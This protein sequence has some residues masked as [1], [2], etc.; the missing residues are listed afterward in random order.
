M[1]PENLPTTP[2]AYDHSE[3]TFWLCVL[4]ADFNELIYATYLGSSPDENGIYGEHTHAGTHKFDTRGIIYHS[5][6]GM[7]QNFPTTPN[8]AFPSTQTRYLDNIA[9]KFDAGF[10][11]PA[12]EFILE[13]G[14]DSITC[15][16]APYSAEFI[17]QSSA[18]DY[19]IWNFGDGSPSV[20]VDISQNISHVFSD[21][22]VFVVSLIAHKDSVCITDDTAFMTIRVLETF[23]PE[24]L[25]QDTFICHSQ[26]LIDI[27]VLI[28][29][30]STTHIISWVPEDGIVGSNNTLMVT[31]NP[32]INNQYWVT[33]TDTGFCKATGTDTITIYNFEEQLPL[34]EVAAACRDNSN[35]A[36]WLIHQ[37]PESVNYN[38]RWH[39]NTDTTILS[40]TDSLANVPNGLYQLNII[41]HNGCQS[42]MFVYIPTEDHKVS[43]F[44]DSII[45]KQDTITFK[46]TS[47]PYFK[48]WY[49]SFGDH[50]VAHTAYPRHVYDT[51]GVF[52]VMLTGKGPVCTDTVYRVIIVDS[53]VTNLHFTTDKDSICTGETLTF[54]PYVDRSA[55][56]LRWDFS[57]QQD[58]WM[59]ASN[60][61]V[62]HAYDRAGRMPV[63]LTASFRACPDISFTDTIWIHPFP[64]VYLG[65]D[66][67]L[68]LNGEPV[69][70]R[71]LAENEPGYYKYLWNVNGDTTE[72]YKVVHPGVYYLSVSN[73]HG[74]TTTESVDV[75]KDCYIDI[76]NVFTPNG[77]G[78]NDYF[79]PRQLLSRKVTSFRMQIFNRWGQVIFSTTNIEGKGW[80][81]KFNDKDQPVGVYVYLIDVTIDHNKQ[82][83]YK[84][85]VTLLR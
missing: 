40:L 52:R 57:D 83:Q 42:T 81:G 71:N 46:N 79:F 53:P 47:D 19:Y 16:A 66:S 3:K 77:D 44:V 76:P 22:G 67:F 85:N 39:A 18:A 13:T 2:D 6:C 32:A 34:P 75:L 35:G 48:E 30:P 27:G 9:F 69:Y 58:D 73:I 60:A 82:E 10:L 68:C 29:N 43:F 50:N 37:F 84:G 8:S 7:S 25:V 65:T 14:Y 59:M 20:T 74:C 38:Y 62:Q 63:T 33:V 80:D 23:I 5:L 1:G 61:M 54:Y 64:K 56:Q 4:G 41:S 72:I 15:G 51:S 70:L 21:T 17:N 31:V 24:L 36:A 45:C 26:Q 78:V 12:A 55:T 28:K 49:W 11:P